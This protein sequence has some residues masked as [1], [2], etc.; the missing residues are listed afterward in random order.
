M[1]G[2]FP[3]AVAGVNFHPDFNNPDQGR[4]NRL[5]V[6][7]VRLTQQ[8][9]ESLSYS[10]A[11]QR[12]S[13]NRRNYNG[14]R[15]EPGSAVFNPFGEFE[16][17]SVNRGTTDTLD[18]R[19]N[20]RVGRSNM[21]TAGFEFEHESAVQDFGFST[22][23]TP[24]DKQRTFAVFAQDQLSFLDDR[25]QF[26][27][28]I[29]GQFFR[30]N[31]ADRPGSLQ[32]LNTK[33]AITGD[34]SVA[35]F[36][37][38]TNTKIRAH[39]GNGFRAPS[40]FERF[41]FGTFGMSIRRFGDPTLKAEQSISFDGGVDQRLAGERVRLGATYFYTRLQRAIVY[42]GLMPDP[43]G[44]RR[45]AGYVNRPG[46]LARGLESYFEMAPA[47]GT[48][49]RAS[50]TFTNSDRAGGF[51]GLLPEY[52]IARHVFGFNFN[53]RYRAFSLNF[54]LNRTGSYIAPLFEND[55]PFRM[56][57]LTFGG[58]T[59]ADLFGSY[60]KKLSERWTTVLFAG[61]DNIFNQRY[62]EN[63]FLAPGFVGRAGVSLKF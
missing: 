3:R 48:E 5:L 27:I 49:I 22:V 20:A 36:F 10:V 8:L 28:G 59:K 15:S 1:G 21:V 41:G 34:G 42:T 12:T 32:A 29:R 63:G 11:Y 19:V 45:V 50:Y 51:G 17:V 44:L 7:S 9:Q 6:G 35:Y 30:L 37:R 56:A 39:V 33:S 46:G 40:L 54:D 23:P 43:L 57:E 4:R 25:L 16:F 24:A 60:E 47:R 55:F 26:S 14:P 53:Q 38:S 31:A 2:E 62:F 61:A 18:A 58:Y 52:V 13:S